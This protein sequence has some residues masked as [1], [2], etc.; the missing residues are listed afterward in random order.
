MIFIVAPLLLILMLVAGALILPFLAL[1]LICGGIWL[2][3]RLF[4]PTPTPA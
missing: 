3:L 4:L 1:G 2:L